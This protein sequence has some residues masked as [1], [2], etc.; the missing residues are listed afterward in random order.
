MEVIQSEVISDL[1]LTYERK[2]RVDIWTH[3]MKVDVAE[4]PQPKSLLD[5]LEASL[6]ALLHSWQ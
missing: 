1:K 5:L 4:H 3:L 6:P 2:R